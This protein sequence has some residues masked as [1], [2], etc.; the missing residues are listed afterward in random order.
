MR[1]KLVKHYAQHDLV[2]QRLQINMTWV[3]PVDGPFTVQNNIMAYE[4]STAH[5]FP[6]RSMGEKAGELR[7]NRLAYIANGA[8]HLWINLDAIAHLIQLREGTSALIIELESEL[9]SRNSRN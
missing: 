8:A 5:L 1:D 6:E 2:K 3:S 4:P 9:G 7:M